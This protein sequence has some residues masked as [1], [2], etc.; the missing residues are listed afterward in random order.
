MPSSDVP[1][2]TEARLV[3]LGPD[4]PHTNRDE[5]SAAR[6]EAAAILELR[7]SSPRNYKNSL[8]FLAGDVNRLRELEQAVRQFLAWSSICHD[9]GL[10][11]DKFQSNQA[12]TKRQNTNEAV[13]LRIGESYHWLLVP[14]QPDPK[15]DVTW[16][17]LKLQ[18]EGSLATRA[19]KKLKNEECLLSQMGAV[20]LRTELDR[21]PLWTGDHVS[22]KQLCE[23]MARYLYLPRLR[24][25]Q[26]LIG[27][28]QEGVSSLL[29]NET[30]AY[31]EGWDDE[32]KRYQGLRAGNITRVIADER[33]LLV[34]PEAAAEQFAKDK[35]AA[36]AKAGNGGAATTTTSGPADGP[37]A[38]TGSGG[39]TDGPTSAPEP[40]RPRRFHGSVKVDPVRLGRDASRIAE[41][42][43][44]HLTGMVGSKVEIT[45]E[46][47]AEL[48]VGASE[49]LVRDVTENCRTLKFT[50]YGFE[51]S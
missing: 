1:D 51:E 20:R 3:I 22:I 13:D 21:I 7:G 31:A 4:S 34:K 30:F 8:V 17:D 40:A 45:L 16:T 25:D 46:I 12:T 44:Q 49:K 26:V 27:A 48:A 14:G 18:G 36:E 11:L 50:D 35:E 2:E 29:W 32:R 24:D 28:I 33:S 5:K 47:Q 23:Y 9:A 19:A 15:G 38:R 6:R 43:L 37:D 39:A 42:I 10:N 41:E